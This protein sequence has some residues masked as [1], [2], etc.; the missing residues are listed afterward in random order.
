[1]RNFALVLAMVGALVKYFFPESGISLYIFIIAGA[2]FLGWVEDT[3][4][5]TVRGWIESSREKVSSQIEE[6]A[7]QITELRTEIGALEKKTEDL[8]E[9]IRLLREEVKP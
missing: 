1:M 9:E 6:L 2:L 5:E 8:G 7:A 3:I 4:S